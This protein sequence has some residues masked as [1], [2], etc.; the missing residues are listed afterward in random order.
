MP[1]VQE[2]NEKMRS[3]SEL[4]DIVEAISYFIE[5][6]DLNGKFKEAALAWSH[7]KMEQ[8]FEVLLDIGRAAIYESYK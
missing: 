4:V 7:Q 1:T 3:I 8:A 5:N 6:S 2:L